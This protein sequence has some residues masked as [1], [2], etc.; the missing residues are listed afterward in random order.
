MSF[1]YDLASAD[2]AI[3]LISEVRLELGDTEAGQGVKPNQSNLSDEEIQRWLTAENSDVMRATGRAVLALANWWATF[4]K[5]ITTGPY[6]EDYGNISDAWAKR[7]AFIM[8]NFPGIG[9]SG[10]LQ[11]SSLRKVDGYSENNSSSESE[12]SA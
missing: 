8:D 7:A 12:Y 5:S 2:P 10:G 4:V 9:G 1:N 6:K 11:S 3:V